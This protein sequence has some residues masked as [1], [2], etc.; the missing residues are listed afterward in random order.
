MNIPNDV[1][2]VAARLRGAGFM[3]V[4]TGGAVRDL[5]LRRPVRD[6]DL[7]TNAAPDQ[8]LLL[9]P[10]SRLITPFGT[11][12]VP[13]RV[14][15]IEIT[16]LRIGD[17]YDDLQQCDRA[18]CF[19]CLRVDLGRRD[20]TINAIAYDLATRSLIDPF[21]GQIDLNARRLRSVGN[22]VA[23]FNEDALRLLRAVRLAAQL[24]FTIEPV[25]YAAICRI[26]FLA[27]Y[28]APERVGMELIKLIQIPHAA[29]GFVVLRDTGLAMVVLPELASQT[30]YN[31]GVATLA[32]LP[33][34]DLALRFAALFH[35]AAHDALIVA[36]MARKKLMDLGIGHHLADK[37][38]S[39]TK[40]SAIDFTPDWSESELIRA[41]RPFDPDV[42]VAGLILR[43]A[44]DQARIGRLDPVTAEMIRR[45]NALYRSDLPIYLRQL[46]INGKDLQREL[47]IPPSQEVGMLLEQLQEAVFE[48]R[49]LNRKDTLLTYARAL[50]RQLSQQ[51]PDTTE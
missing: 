38:S 28:L 36:D 45:V 27:R 6:W 34:G 18:D 3:A 21:G 42:V 50:R 7:V 9:F 41:I 46:A 51:P 1:D 49:L 30:A 22:P 11:V 32:A 20:F 37:V 26:S 10:N 14:S 17:R 13:A 35:Y 2:A 48:R 47:N 16:P 29:T 40:V 24:D 25:T 8:I 39:L 5:L 23:R 43:A 33:S 4:V 44:C 12:M 15:T 31:L 19:D